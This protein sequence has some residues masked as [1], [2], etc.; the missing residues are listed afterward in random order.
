VSF[1]LPRQVAKPLVALKQ[2]VDRALMG[3]HFTEFEPRG[4]GEVA[5]LARSVQN[6]I[7]QLTAAR[8]TLSDCCQD[9]R[10]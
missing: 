6:L 8:Q 5:E 10:S 1:V 3:D 4:S 7:A 9:T 2:A